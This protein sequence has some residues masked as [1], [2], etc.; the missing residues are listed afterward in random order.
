MVTLGELVLIQELHRQGLSISAIAQQVGRDRKTVRR[1]INKGLEPPTYKPRPKQPR[2]IEAY[3]PYI[4]ERIALFPTMSAQRLLRE[5]IEKGYKGKYT[6]VRKFVASVKPPKTR[7]FERRFETPPGK[8]AQIDFA[9]FA[10]SF[11]DED[12]IDDQ[13]V[14]TPVNRK[15]WLFSFVLGH[16][17]WLW[18]SFCPNQNLATVLRCHVA[19]LEELRSLG[20]GA[21]QETLYDRMKTAVIG[22]DPN[23]VLIF[24]ESLTA[25]LSYYDITPRA[26]KAYRP[27]TK[28]KVER[29]FRYIRE[30]F[31]LGR[32]FKNMED[33]NQ[34]FTTWRNEVAN[35]R[36][37]ATTG[38]FISEA[39]A[40][41]CSALTALPLQPYDAVLGVE[42]RIT[43]DGM[44]S[45]DGNL[46]SVPNGVKRRTVEIQIH[47]DTI[48]IYE[49]SNLIAV[50]PVLQGKNG[51]R[52]DPAH[53]AVKP[54]ASLPIQGQANAG[55]QGVQ[56]RP[57]E[58][59]DDIA[60][61]LASQPVPAA[62]LS[63]VPL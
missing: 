15:V 37:H 32:T 54:K 20:G 39:V 49:Q 11:T 16:S 58:V 56:T 26:C 22:E 59:Y 43:R 62:S 30:D 13:G 2:L 33:L 45:V 19:A 31:F 41:E 36:K 61:I 28:G 25:L 60:A 18:G 12:S 52:V 29:P 9:E 4:R 17:R 3:E 10:V 50:H 53:R 42:R 5:I 63:G 51:R 40:E 38:R 55:H 14:V 44:V 7:E 8:Q 46:Y 27:K 35:A 34:Q 24:N 57:L 1:H 21:P 23:G 6:Q 47:T 48:K